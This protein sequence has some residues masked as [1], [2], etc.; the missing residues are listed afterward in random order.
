MLHQCSHTQLHFLSL[1]A[2][3]SGSLAFTTSILFK[4]SVGNVYKNIVSHVNISLVQKSF[5]GQYLVFQ[6]VDMNTL[7]LF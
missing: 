2:G 1:L 6:S 4:A 7:Q 3:S 5:L